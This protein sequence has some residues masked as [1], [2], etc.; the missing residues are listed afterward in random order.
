MFSLNRAQIVGNATRDPEMRYTPNGQAVCSFGVATNRRWRDKDGNNQEQAEFHNIVAWGKL[1]ELMSQLVHKGTKIYLE[2]RL[3]TR[4]WEGQDGNQRNR[5]EIVME[6]FIVFTPKGA[7]P[8]DV[9]TVPGP[10]EFPGR[11]KKEEKPLKDT[12]DK[13]ASKEKKSVKSPDETKAD[14]ADDEI[15]L[16]EIPF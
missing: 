13:P 15:N 14:T 10:E 7:A 16:D 3:Q 6:D 5:T 11:E 2:G 4:Q 8:T 12:Q 9:D 1:A